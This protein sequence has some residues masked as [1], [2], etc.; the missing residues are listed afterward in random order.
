MILYMLH[1]ASKVELEHH[2]KIFR[3]VVE[4]IQWFAHEQYARLR[5]LDLSAVSRAQVVS[6]L[7]GNPV[8]T[9]EV[10]ARR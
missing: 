2:R 10:I 3:N 7:N 5:Q 1:H 9:M 8:A 4:Q 6:K